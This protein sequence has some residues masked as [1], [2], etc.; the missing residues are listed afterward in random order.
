[1]KK[2]IVHVG[3]PKTATTTIQECLFTNLQKWGFINYL[4]ITYTD[5]RIDSYCMETFQ[6][7][8]KESKQFKV[9]QGNDSNLWVYS[10]EKLSVPRNIIQNWLGVSG[11]PEEI[12][13]KIYN[14]YGDTFNNIEI[15]IVLRNQSSLI[16]SFFA[17]AMPEF[18][19]L[20]KRY[21]LEDY[22][23]DI[24]VNPKDHEIWEHYKTVKSYMD[25]F[26]SAKVHVLLF[27]EFLQNRD[28]FNSKIAK[29]LD[30][31]KDVVVDAFGGGHINSKK[32]SKS[33]IEVIKTRAHVLR[34]IAGNIRRKK[35]IGRILSKH[36]ALW[37]NNVIR[38]IYHRIVYKKELE[39]SIDLLLKKRLFCYYN[40][41]NKHLIDLCSIDKG[42]LKKYDYIE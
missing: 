29:I 40:E 27:E 31:E 34:K 25:I 24:S 20:Y 30:I 21:T 19:E 10:E 12:A 14:Y 35:T 1:M 4:G 39:P 26:G 23:N 42:V 22:V 6:E 13:E 32:M 3:L 17:Q 2:L 37:E 11:S 9:A 15:L 41:S 8:I 16:H 28:S 5:G 38:K 7:I 33:G 36:P 18:T